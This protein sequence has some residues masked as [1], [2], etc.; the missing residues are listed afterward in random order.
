MHGLSTI[1]KL[2]R[3]NTE[4][5]RIA[6]AADPAGKREAKVKQELEQACKPAIPAK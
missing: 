6:N 2:N 5:N 4:A 1:A 3:Q